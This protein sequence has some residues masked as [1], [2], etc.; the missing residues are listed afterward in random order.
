MPVAELGAIAVTRGILGGGVALLFGDRL[1]AETRKNLGIVLFAIGIIS[2]LPL[3]A[4]VM[5]RRMYDDR[6]LNFT[7]GLD[8]RPI[9]S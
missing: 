8:E 4:D 1:P 9:L 6:R 2:T 3:I 7:P 5:R